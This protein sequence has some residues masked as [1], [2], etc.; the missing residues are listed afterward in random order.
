MYFYF[1]SILSLEKKT[2]KY[3]HLNI[4]NDCLFG[5]AHILIDNDGYVGDSSYIFLACIHRLSLMGKITVLIKHRGH[6]KK[7]PEGNSII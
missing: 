4:D 3:T 7:N 6:N 5:P 1:I 2:R